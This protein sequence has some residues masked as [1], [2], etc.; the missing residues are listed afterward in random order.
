MVLVHGSY[1]ELSFHLCEFRFFF[2]NSCWPL[3]NII[4]QSAQAIAMIQVQISEPKKST[5]SFATTKCRH[6]GSCWR[7]VLTI[8]RGCPFWC[9]SSS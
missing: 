5:R 2:S 8:P 3:A 9:F 6:A 7:Q 1:F 4:I